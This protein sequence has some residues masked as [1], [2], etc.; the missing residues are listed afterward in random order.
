MCLQWITLGPNGDGTVSEHKEWEPKH[1]FNDNKGMSDED[2]QKKIADKMAAD[3]KAAELEKKR[4]DEERK[5]K[6]E[7][8]RKARKERG[9]KIVN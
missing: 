4:K 7:E 3:N 8:I 1:S 9:K 2:F 6:L 5:K